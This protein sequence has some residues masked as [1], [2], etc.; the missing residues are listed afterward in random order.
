M[1]N[2]F[3][4]LILFILYA[5]FVWVTYGSFYYNQYQ[6][7]EC[8]SVMDWDEEIYRGNW[9]F[10]ITESRWTQTYFKQV[11]QTP[12]FPRVINER[13]SDEITAKQCSDL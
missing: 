8:V 9:A 13:I 3:S 10:F 4:S 7:P 6:W 12:L 1:W 11:E 5:M 2:F